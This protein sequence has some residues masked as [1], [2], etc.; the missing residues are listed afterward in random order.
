MGQ[1]EIMTEDIQ[2][3]RKVREGG[4]QL[5]LKIPLQIKRID[6]LTEGPGPLT[7]KLRLGQGVGMKG[8]ELQTE[9]QQLQKGN[10]PIKINIQDCPT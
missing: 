10:F 1:R 5:A 3:Q 9:G 8:K 4:L 7:E 2:G 6:F